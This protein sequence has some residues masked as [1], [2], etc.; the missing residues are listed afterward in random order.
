MPDSAINKHV[1][2]AIMEYCPDDIYLNYAKFLSIYDDTEHDRLQSFCTQVMIEL[3]KNGASFQDEKNALSN[4]TLATFNI[5]NKE[6]DIVFG[7]H[8]KKRFDK[9]FMLPLLSVIL[10]YHPNLSK[11]AQMPV[12]A[13]FSSLTHPSIKEVGHIA[14]VSLEPTYLD[15]F[16]YAY[17]SLR[18]AETN[19]D[20][21]EILLTRIKDNCDTAFEPIANLFFNAFIEFE[22]TGAIEASIEAF[23]IVKLWCIR[24]GDMSFKNEEDILY[25]LVSTS[26]STPFEIDKFSAKSIQKYLK[27]H[28]I[29][30]QP[31]MELLANMLK[32]AISS[33]DVAYEKLSRVDLNELTSQVPI[34]NNS[35]EIKKLEEQL[36]LANKKQKAIED[37][38]TAVENKLR[39]LQK[40]NEW[41]EAQL[42]K[43]A[44]EKSTKPNITQAQSHMQE[45]KASNSILLSNEC[46]TS[47]TEMVAELAEKKYVLVG[48]DNNFVNK[49]KE[50]FPKWKYLNESV[51]TKKKINS[52]INNI[53]CILFVASNLDHSSF[54]SAIKTARVHNIPYAFV[55][56]INIDQLIKSL[57][58]HAISPEEEIDDLSL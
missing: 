35:N 30:D 49:L 57:Y 51:V 36:E 4:I 27:E 19:K 50:L 37:A 33:T 5:Y 43:N 29:Y 2:H 40:R 15:N 8:I 25:R 55:K 10:A 46:G 24:A 28:S 17:R 34:Q 9:Y 3:A 1:E 44:A 26:W 16:L 52:Y 38:K 20:F 14:L 21:K 42:A 31:E 12:D 11:I 39:S 41:L 56:S 23:S 7:D 13:T 53:D 22:E 32:Y 58:E 54:G 48:G 6:F 45:K 47:K 18:Y